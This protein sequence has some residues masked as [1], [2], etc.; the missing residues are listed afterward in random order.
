MRWPTKLHRQGEQLDCAPVITVGI[1]LSPFSLDA[2]GAA[3]GLMQEERR[4]AFVGARS[5][6]WC[7][8]LDQDSHS[9]LL[10]LRA[11]GALL[12]WVTRASRRTLCRRRGYLSQSAAEQT[13]TAQ[14]SALWLILFF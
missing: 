7:E 1:G 10:L 13:A 5:F 8:A 4:P 3:A 9:V 14:T 11:S 12:F 6:G 2:L